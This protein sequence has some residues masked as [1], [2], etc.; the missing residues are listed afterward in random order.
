MSAEYH[1]DVKTKCSTCGKELLP[2]DLGKNWRKCHFC[3]EPMCFDDTHY[4][5]VRVK[6][7]YNDYLDVV[8]VCKKCYPK[9]L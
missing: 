2:N 6:G 7:L 5:S 4:L 9:G 8:P 3:G 1:Q